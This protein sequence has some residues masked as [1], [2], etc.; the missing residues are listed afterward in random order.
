MQI[1]GAAFSPLG[2]MCSEGIF[3]YYHSMVMICNL[4]RK[5]VWIWSGRKATLVAWPRRSGSFGLPRWT[6]ATCHAPSRSRP[7]LSRFATVAKLLEAPV[8][9]ISMLYLVTMRF[10]LQICAHAR[11]YPAGSGKAAARNGK[12]TDFILEI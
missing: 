3:Y 1:S 2:H 4:C 8:S 7:R 12:A 11:G 5:L 10:T 9:M 6:S